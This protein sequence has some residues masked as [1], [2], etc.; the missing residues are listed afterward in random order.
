MRQ[1]LIHCRATVV[2]VETVFIWSELGLSYEAC[3]AHC[4]LRIH[5]KSTGEG[6]PVGGS[7]FFDFTGHIHYHQEVA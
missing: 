2:Y 6:P 4:Y 5:S 1:K 7:L 3:L